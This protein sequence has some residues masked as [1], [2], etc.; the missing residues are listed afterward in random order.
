MT[1]NLKTKYHTHTTVHHILNLNF[2][3]SFLTYTHETSGKRTVI[4]VSGG[5]KL[6][7]SRKS[8]WQSCAYSELYLG[9]SKAFS[10]I[11]GRQQTQQNNKDR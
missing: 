6:G 3:T 5:S 10:K 1:Y 8:L 4:L 7:A 11:C 2:P 9:S